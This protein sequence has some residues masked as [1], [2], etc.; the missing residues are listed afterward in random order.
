MSEYKLLIKT[1]QVEGTRSLFRF[2]GI[3]A[4][5]VE[6]HPSV[7]GLYRCINQVGY[8]S[9]SIWDGMRYLFTRE[10]AVVSPGQRLYVKGF[11]QI[12][13]YDTGAGLQ[14]FDEDDWSIHFVSETTPVSNVYTV[15]VGV[16]SIRVQAT[17]AEEEVFNEELFYVAATGGCRPLFI[18]VKDKWERLDMG[19]EKPALTIQSND[20]AE[21]KDRQAEYTQELILPLTGRNLRILGHPHLSDSDTDSPYKFWECRLFAGEN[22]LARKGAVLSI[23]GVTDEGIECQIL[24]AAIGLFD[25]LNEAPMSDITE[26]SITWSAGGMFEPSGDPGILDVSPITGG[27]VAFA[28]F[29]RGKEY[30]VASLGSRYNLPFIYAQ[31]MVEAILGQHGFSWEHNL[32][33]YVGS[34]RFALPVVDAQADED[35]FADF[36][37]YGGL[38][39]YQTLSTSPRYLIPVIESSGVGMLTVVGSNNSLEDAYVQYMS[40]VEATLNLRVRVAWPN[41]AVED[42]VTRELNVVYNG[43]DLMDYTCEFGPEAFEETIQIK[44]SPGVPVVISLRYMAIAWGVN[45]NLVADFEVEVTNFVSERVP[46]GGKIHLPRNLGFETQGD[47]IKAFI[48]A[49]GLFV[50]VDRSNETVYTYTAKKIYDNK[51]YAVDWTHKLSGGQPKMVFDLGYAQVNSIPM[52]EN[53]EDEVEDEA[54]FGVEDSTLEVKKTLFEL[55]F[56]AGYDWAR[57]AKVAGVQVTDQVANIPVFTKGSDEDATEQENL[58]ASELSTGQPHLVRIGETSR[59]IKSGEY[60]YAFKIACKVASHVSAQ[61]LVDTFYSELVSGMLS[62]SKVL[63]VELN[64]SALDI[65]RFDP[66]VPVYLKQHGA[67]FYVNKISNFVSGQLTT[68]ELIKL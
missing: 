37:A 1:G 53:S 8:V 42:R 32:D 54:E 11:T 16:R 26:P 51:P 66:F 13:Q 39:A 33:E 38:T 58:D 23:D 45:E 21:L 68:V 29:F 52:K 35:S 56:E 36:D 22:Q 18:G 41:L 9:E 55:P 30:P 57:E 60:P 48:Q 61:E 59:L 67:F 4:P 65:E 20:L 2:D 46:Y 6:G 3:K 14:S 62:G 12:F 31:W 28:S 64:L 43:E 5:G 25:T 24:G 50:N 17:L 10:G 47:F 63:T 44:V 15:P 49:H 34:E 40:P 27:V 19:S 7:P